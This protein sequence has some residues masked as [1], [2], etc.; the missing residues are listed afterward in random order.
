MTTHT[1]ELMMIYESIFTYIYISCLY[2]NT[3]Y[4]DNFSVRYV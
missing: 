1:F 3:S 4:E 2:A